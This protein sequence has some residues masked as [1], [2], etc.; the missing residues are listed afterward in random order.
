MISK[1]DELLTIAQ[2]LDRVPLFSGQIAGQRELDHFLLERFR[3]LV[4]QQP[5]RPGAESNRPRPEPFF[6]QA[7]QLQS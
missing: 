5:L 1:G 6:S 2:D 7:L 3:S 4:N